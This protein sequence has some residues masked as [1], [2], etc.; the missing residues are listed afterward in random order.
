MPV[1]LTDWWTGLA[2]GFLLVCRAAGGLYGE[3]LFGG[4]VLRRGG[5]LR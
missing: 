4:L 1:W 2:D 5:H 3:V